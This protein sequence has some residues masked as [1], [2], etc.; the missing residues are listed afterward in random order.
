M[1]TKK[2]REALDLMK[3]IQ[4]YSTADIHAGAIAEVEAIEKAAVEWVDSEVGELSQH[5]AD[6]LDAIATEVFNREGKP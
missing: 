5:G 4:G 1:S 6:T 2:I 3:E